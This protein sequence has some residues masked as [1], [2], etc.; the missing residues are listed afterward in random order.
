MKLGAAVGTVLATVA[1]L[2]TFAAPA[3]AAQPTDVAGSGA[4]DV[5][6]GS[7]SLTVSFNYGS[8][9]VA[10][11]EVTLVKVATWDGRLPLAGH[12]TLVPAM[13]EGEFGRYPI[14]LLLSHGSEES[15]RELS[16]ALFEIID[17]HGAPEGSVS[18]LTGADGSVTFRGLADGVY[19]ANGIGLSGEGRSG[20]AVFAAQLTMLGTADGATAG[21]HVDSVAKGTLERPVSLILAYLEGFEGDSGSSGDASGGTGGDSAGDSTGSGSS[22][23]GVLGNPGQ[24]S[25]DCA[26]SGSSGSGVLGNPGQESGGSAGSG[27]SGDAAGGTGSGDE[28]DC[29][30]SGSAFSASAAAAAETGAP[31]VGTAIVAVAAL[32][33]GIVLAVVAKRKRGNL[34]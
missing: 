14:E 2:G 3:G 8:E 26:G 25:T 29:A 15:W 24:E 19:F 33:L 13:K 22:G 20:T 7:N 32:G 11:A 23:D 30:D 21:E 10:G 16:A 4:V 5:G 34:E 28:A 18:A 9:P 12:V 27:S 6:E 1:A 31:I 17:E